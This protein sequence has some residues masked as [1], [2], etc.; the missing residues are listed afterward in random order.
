M[1]CGSIVPYTAKCWCG[2]GLSVD[3]A[4]AALLAAN[5]P[6]RTLSILDEARVV[7]S[8]RQDRLNQRDRELMERGYYENVLDMER[9]LTA[10][11][12]SLAVSESQIIQNLIALYKALGGGWDPDAVALDATAG[13]P[14]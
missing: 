9:A 14:S 7:A 5:A 1:G 3:E 4:K 6:R 12:D 13:G 11:Q 8:L 2:Y 10:Q